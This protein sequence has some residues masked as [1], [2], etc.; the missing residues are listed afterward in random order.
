MG[1]TGTRTESSSKHPRP[2]RPGCF[3][4]GPSGRVG[5]G[6]RVDQGIR[7]RYGQSRWPRCCWSTSCGSQLL[8]AFENSDRH[9]AAVVVT[10]IAV[11][12]NASVS[13]LPASRMFRR[14]HQWSPPAARSGA[15]GH[16]PTRT[17]G[18]RAAK[19][20]AIWFLLQCGPHCS[21]LPSAQW[22]ERRNGGWS[23]TE[24]WAPHWVSRW[25]C[26][27][28]TSVQ[29]DASGSSRPRRRYRNR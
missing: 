17:R 7:G 13:I 12:V 8:V 11:L 4:N 6:I 2:V 24:S 15:Y 5:R 10:A 3:L 27:V 20:P 21:R 26:S 28:C 1:I 19:C 9:L 16:W 18:P 23:S 14:A 29:S 25:R 22:R